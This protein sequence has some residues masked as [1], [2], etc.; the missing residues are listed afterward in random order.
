MQ[1]ESKKIKDSKEERRKR[2]MV[3]PLSGGTGSK[4]SKTVMMMLVVGLMM[5]HKEA[6]ASS[7]GAIRWEDLPSGDRFLLPSMAKVEGRNISY[8]MGA[9]KLEGQARSQKH[10]RR[11]I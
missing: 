9:T 11:L 1:E 10:P 4:F 2:K 3:K 6:A 8:A 5:G 7:S